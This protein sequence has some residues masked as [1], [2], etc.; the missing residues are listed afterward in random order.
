MFKDVLEYRCETNSVVCAQ[1]DRL[2]VVEKGFKRNKSIGVYAN[3]TGTGN[4]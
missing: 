1:Q 2:C 4:P 3:W